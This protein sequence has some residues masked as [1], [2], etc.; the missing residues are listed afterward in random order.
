MAK[1]FTAPGPGPSLAKAP[2]RSSE[3]HFGEEKTKDFTAQDIR[4]TTKGTTLYAICLGWPGEKLVIKS[5]AADA[6]H[7][8]GQIAAI[9]L[10]GANG[11]AEMVASRKRSDGLLPGG[12]ALPARLR[13]ENLPPGLP[14][15][16]SISY[17]NYIPCD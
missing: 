17:S 10:L 5:L 16:V 4:F 11:Q 14:G 13:L 6:P 9:H 12:E 8:A 3:G 1:P 7:F 15:P 2:R